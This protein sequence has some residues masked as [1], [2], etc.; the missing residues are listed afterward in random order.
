MS[1]AG[2]CNS[3]MYAKKFFRHLPYL[4]ACRFSWFGYD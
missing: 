2:A 4:Y 1:V 3:K